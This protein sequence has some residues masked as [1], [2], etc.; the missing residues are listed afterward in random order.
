MT[1]NYRPPS[2]VF[3]EPYGEPTGPDINVGTCVY[4]PSRSVKYVMAKNVSATVSVAGA[5]AY[6]A[7]AVYGEMGKAADALGPDNCEGAWVAAVPA[8]G[9]GYVAVAGAP[10]NVFGTFSAGDSLTAT[11]DVFV[12]GAIATALIKGKA[13]DTAAA[14]LGAARLG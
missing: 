7:S 4:S 9:F 6:Q 12:A 8:G 11:A 3:T 10:I 5:P 14:A 2:T 1:T 13:I